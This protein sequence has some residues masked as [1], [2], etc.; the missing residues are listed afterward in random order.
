MDTLISAMRTSA[1]IASSIIVIVALTIIIWIVGVK[2]AEPFGI[3]LFNMF[4]GMSV[5][6]DQEASFAQ[7][8]KVVKTSQHEHRKIAERQL[9]GFV[10]MCFVFCTVVFELTLA[11]VGVKWTSFSD[12]C[13]IVLKGIFE[14]F[15]AL[16]MLRMA[17]AAVRR[18][19]S[20]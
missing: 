8:E 15:V 17:L 2:L 12:F 14:A 16:G 1:I 3:I 13:I 10:A 6:D 20:N 5:P 11:D 7:Q 18:L 19:V 9:S 4:A